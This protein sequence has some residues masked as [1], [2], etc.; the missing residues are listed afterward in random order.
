VRPVRL[1]AEPRFGTGGP[2]VAPS[3]GTPQACTAVPKPPCVTDG[4]FVGTNTSPM[5]VSWGGMTVCHGTDPG[6][7][8]RQ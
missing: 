1:I 2:D 5:T 6:A 7:K 3:H 8:E 4:I